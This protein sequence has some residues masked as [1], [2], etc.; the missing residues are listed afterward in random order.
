MVGG[1]GER[2]IPHARRKRRLST[3]ANLVQ[4]RAKQTPNYYYIAELAKSP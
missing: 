4:R 3:T 2:E 1:E